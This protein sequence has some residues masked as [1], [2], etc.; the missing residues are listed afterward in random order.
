M[1]NGLLE[2]NT[3]FAE[4]DREH[5]FSLFMN[6]RNMYNLFRIHDKSDNDAKIRAYDYVLNN[7]TDTIFFE[8]Q[9]RHRNLKMNDCFLKY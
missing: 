1:Q 9:L 6:I 8:E 5:F 4:M 2:V 3:N 7:F